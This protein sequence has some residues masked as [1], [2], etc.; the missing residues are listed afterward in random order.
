[1][2]KTIYYFGNIDSSLDNAVI[3]IIPALK[4]EFPKI[5]FKYLDPNEDLSFDDDNPVILDTAVE[6][7]EPTLITDLNNIAIK[8]STTM[9]D[10]D[11]GFNL[12]L[13]KKLGRIKDVR[14][15]GVPINIV[16]D[17][18]RDLMEQIK[19]LLEIL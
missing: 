18:L 16:P 13:L 15:I 7:R 6:L 4:K 5:K 11:L 19:Q 17:E 10:F 8:K 2:L 1:M 3:K 14:I 9:H 12:K